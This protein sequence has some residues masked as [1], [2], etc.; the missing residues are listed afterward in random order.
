MPLQKYVHDSFIFLNGSGHDSA[1]KLG[2]AE[3]IAGFQRQEAA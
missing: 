3:S 1:T 2:I